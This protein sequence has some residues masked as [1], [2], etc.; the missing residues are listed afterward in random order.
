MFDTREDGVAI[1][2]LDGRRSQEERIERVAVIGGGIA[3]LACCHYLSRAGVKVTLFESSDQFGGLG[4]FFRYGDAY[5]ERFYHCMLPGDDNLLELLRDLGIEDRV[6]WRTAEFGFMSDG[7]LYGLNT[8]AELLAFSPLPLISRLRV[9]LTAL[10]A[11]T[12]P[13]DGLDDITAEQ[14]LTRLCGRR[15]FEIFWKPMF[16]A[17][18]GDRYH[19]I[20]ALWFWTRFN[21]EKGT[22]KE[23]KGY[24]RGGYRYLTDRL[25]S[26]LRDRG[27]VL[28]LNAPVHSLRLDGQRRPVLHSGDSHHLFDHVVVTTPLSHCR[29][30]ANNDTMEPWNRR[31]SPDIDYQGVVNVVLILRRGLTPYYWVAAMDGRFPFQGIV[32]SSVLLEKEDAGGHHLVYLMNYLHRNDER[33]KKGDAEVISEAVQGLAALFPGFRQSDIVDQFVFRA[34]YVEPLYTLG[35]LSKKPPEELVPG[36][37]Y[38][39][40]SSQVYPAVTSWNSSVG[41]A[42]KVATQ[43]LEAVREKGRWSDLRS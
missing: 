25:V 2:T 8:P 10:Y 1:P 6:Y 34:P 37:V 4:T 30:L 21:R 35:Y 11:S 19:E 16:Q 27:V 31:V 9:G 7:R 5:L 36:R 15:A 33:F 28:R 23:V 24:I 18:F 20:P 17:K 43:V 12:I 3:G 38:L 13:A 39:A 14:W 42:Q 29:T 26:S 32:E 22:K 40:T 41:L